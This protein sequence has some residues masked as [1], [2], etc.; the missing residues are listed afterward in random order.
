MFGRNSFHGGIH[1]PA[2][3]ERTAHSP[4]ALLPLPPKVIIRL[5]QY[6]GIPANP[7]VRH[8][9]YVRAGQMIAELAEQV[10]SPIHASV[11]GKVLRIGLFSYPDGSR[12]PA[13]EIEN[14]GRREATEVTTMDKSW[15]EAAPGELARIITAAGVVDM[16]RT[17]LPAQALLSPS[18][19]SPIHTLIVSG[20]EDEPYVTADCRL[21]LEN[22][23]EIL[24]GTL[25]VKKI[26]G[27]QRVFIAVEKTNQQV[28]AKLSGSVKDPKYKDIVLARLK[29]K[30]PQG[31]ERMLTKTLAK[32]QVPSG[33]SPADIGCIVINVATAF[34]VFDA[35]VNGIPL[36]QRVVTVSGPAIRSPKNVLAPVGTPIRWLL[37]FCGAEADR[38]HKVVLGGPIT[39]Q[40]QS[41]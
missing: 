19:L 40:A 30:Y 9:D 38:L 34:A 39:G 25:I 22:T 6:A 35:V 17:A 21:M 7:L 12:G 29:P 2:E 24:T 36:Y 31:S 37:D 16:G 26:L 32:K 8:G 18:S 10:S 11:S 28:V 41:D 23:E 13:I 15:R 1:P 4:I 33:G 5:E 20:V 3:K 27:A 14:D